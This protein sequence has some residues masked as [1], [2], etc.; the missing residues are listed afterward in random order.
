MMVNA[1]PLL[2]GHILTMVIGMGV[3]FGSGSRR[4]KLLRE[5]PEL[6]LSLTPGPGNAGLGLALHF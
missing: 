1:G 3:D 5:H 4:R 6:A 2:I